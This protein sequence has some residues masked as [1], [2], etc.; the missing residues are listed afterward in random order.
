MPSTS[1]QDWSSEASTQEERRSVAMANLA[2]EG[3]R[4]VEEACKW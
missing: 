2:K 3:S 1:L 4:K